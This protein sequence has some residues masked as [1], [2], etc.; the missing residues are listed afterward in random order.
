MDLLANLESKELSTGVGK[1]NANNKE[2]SKKLRSSVAGMMD[3]LANLEN[4]TT[5]SDKP[6]QGNRKSVVDMMSTLSAL[7]QPPVICKPIQQ[8]H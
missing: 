3:L 6:K 8:N 7:Q 2:E 4:T 1:T 5:T